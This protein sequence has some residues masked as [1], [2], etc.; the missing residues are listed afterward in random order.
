MSLANDLRA[1]VRERAGANV[2]YARDGYRVSL[3]PV[4]DRHSDI[5]FILW[6][7]DAAG[8]V[9]IVAGRAVGGRIVVDDPDFDGNPA[10]LEAVI[11]LLIED[12]QS[13]SGPAPSP[14]ASVPT[15]K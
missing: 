10:E 6:R 11:R 12:G 7:D 15:G 8:T 9:P 5:G 3:N 2:E 1:I 14:E 13:S 4:G